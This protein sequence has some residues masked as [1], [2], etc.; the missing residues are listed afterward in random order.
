MSPPRSPPP[1]GCSPPRASR[2]SSRRSRSP[3]SSTKPIPTRSSTI[4]PSPSWSASSPARGPSAPPRSSR[5]CTAAA[6][7]ARE[8]LGGALGPRAG[9]LADQDG[10]GAIVDDRVGIG[11]VDDVGDRERRE[12]ARDARGGEQPEGGGDRGGDIEHGGRAGERRGDQA[13]EHRAGALGGAV[14]EAGD[15][16]AHGAGE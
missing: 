10:D 14:E 7:Q 3:T 16:A 4:A 5:A 9:E 11:F 2:A 12:L 6:V 8:D 15:P 13:A 1:S